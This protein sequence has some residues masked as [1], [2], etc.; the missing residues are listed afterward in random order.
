M[1]AEAPKLPVVAPVK[2][3]ASTSNML[4]VIAQAAANPQVDVPKMAMLLELQDKL[5]AR[6]AENE[7]NRALARMNTQDLRV[8]KLGVVSVPGKVSYKF[9]KWEDM[10]R[11]IRPLMQRECF[12]LSF[13]TEPNPAGGIIVVGEL[14][15]E[16]GHRR[17]ARI[18]LTI[19]TG[20][21]RNQLQQ[22]G[23][24]VS[25]GKR[26]VTEMLLNI[27]REEED[28]DGQA[29]GETR[30]PPPAP[31]PRNART[32]AAPSAAVWTS[33]EA[34]LSG[35]KNR[36]EWFKILQR[37]ASEVETLDELR[38]IQQHHIVK[39]MLKSDKTPSLFK[40]NIEDVLREAGER[41]APS[42][43]EKLSEPDAL[44]QMANDIVAQFAEVDDQR[45]YD[46][47]VMN[48]AVR[49]QRERLARE[50]PELAELVTK[51]DFAAIARF[52]PEGEEEEPTVPE[53]PGDRK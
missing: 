26:Y 7:F 15:H 30:Q 48:T 18:P 6:E 37:S 10:D 24:T 2:D 50:R 44:D 14:L 5:L 32:Y 39:A 52:N 38:S 8:S 43:T 53:F 11:V 4:S 19:D 46:E 22:M 20:P 51:A 12:T 49:S 36:T 23:S 42:D 29:G 28:D 16:G 41:L 34:K 1:D 17:K 3:G 47:L 33:I 31:M 13:D 45:Q 9:A 27:V 25:Y 35:E 21:G 40:K